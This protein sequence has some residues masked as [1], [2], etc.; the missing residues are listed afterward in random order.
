MRSRYFFLL[1]NTLVLLDFFIIN[2]G[3]LSL[4]IYKYAQGIIYPFN[5][6]LLLHIVLFNIVWAGCA[7]WLKLY[8]IKTLH[9]LITI[10]RATG[11]TTLL[12]AAILLIVTL[13]AYDGTVHLKI[14]GLV[15][16]YVTIILLFLASR[17]CITYIVEFII[18]K[19]NFK[20]KVAIVG[21]NE[22]AQQLAAYFNH[23]KS[24]YSF[25]GFFDD[26]QYFSKESGGNVLA[27]FSECVDYAVATGI[28]EIYS[29]VLPRESGAVQEMVKQAENNCVRIKFVTDD[30]QYTAKHPNYAF[31]H[32]GNFRIITLR[33]EPL[34]TFRNKVKKRLYDVILSSLVIVFILSWLVPLM[35]ILIKLES[36]G[37]VFFVQK[38]SGRNNTI[39]HCI[40][41]RTMRV[42]DQTGVQ[43]KKN[44][45]RITK[46]GAFLR[47][48]SLDEFPQ[49]MN[50]LMGDMS[51]TGPR[52]H[53]IEHTEQYSKIIN[54]Y[55]I[56]HFLK[57]GITGWA[58]V[59]GFRGETEQEIMMRKRV[60]HDIWYMENWSL[61]LDIKILFM[62]IINIFK[63]DE[64]AY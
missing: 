59:K 9:S 26:E 53:M 39:F 29:L 64:M 60:E 54:G 31:M 6:T 15:V 4:Y 20:R 56:R 47:K 2:A 30:I 21:Y 51:I 25:E 46:V 49:F 22:K 48:R 12:H 23:S 62:T 5:Y 41:F 58:Q 38:R 55:M 35:A 32:T 27:P 1:R 37:P 28:R 33:T 16:C 10:Y 13:A 19:G 63:A 18:D 52:P 45:N 42:N 11:K 7:Y 40:K 61:M 43:A 44:D 36:R 14:L 57:A 8:N 50:V 3:L 24:T 34:E 17:F